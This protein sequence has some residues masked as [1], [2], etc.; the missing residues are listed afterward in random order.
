MH[1]FT[2]VV[3]FNFKLCASVFFALLRLSSYLREIA[4]VVGVNVIKYCVFSMCYVIGYRIGT[5]S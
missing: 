2:K 3:L 5:I 1:I 4:L